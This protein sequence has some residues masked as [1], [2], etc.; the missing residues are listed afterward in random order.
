MT[1]LAAIGFNWKYHMAPELLLALL[2]IMLSFII[3]GI[4]V[5]NFTSFLS[6]ISNNCGVSDILF[7]AFWI[8]HLIGTMEP[9]HNL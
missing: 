6:K 4:I 5:S 1:S 9:N 7:S 8:S 2:S 3:L